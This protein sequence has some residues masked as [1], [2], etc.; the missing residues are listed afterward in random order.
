MNKIIDSSGWIEYF[1]G[2][3]NGNNFADAIK[4]VESLLVPSITIFEVFKKFYREMGETMA[5]EVTAAMRKG[6]VIDLDA[7]LAILSA[8]IGHE[9]GL[10]AAD[11][12]IYATAWL[13][14]AV[15]WTQD[16]DFKN[17]ERVKYFKKVP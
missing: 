13:Y 2:T 1:A 5:I 11:S 16:A 7:D 3:E 12:I 10:R 4:D 6:R 9:M 8:K 15:L 17:L 14:S